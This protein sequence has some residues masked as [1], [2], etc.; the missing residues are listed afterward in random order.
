VHRAHVDGFFIDR[1]PVTNRQFAAFV[2]ATGYRTVAERPPNPADYPGAL[3]H[4][5]KT[6]LAGFSQ[7]AGTGRFA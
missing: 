4:I 5:L 3:P 2:A 1:C 7:N 6:W